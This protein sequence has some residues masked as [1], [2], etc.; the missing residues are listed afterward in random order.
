[1]KNQKKIIITGF[2]ASGKDY[3]ADYLTKKGFK[4]STSYTTRP[5]RINEVDGDVYNFISVEKFQEMI[6][7]DEFYEYEEFL[8]QWYYGSTKKDWNDSNL[9]IKTAG[10]IDQIKKEDRENCFIVYL[11][12][13]EEIILERLAERNDSNDSIQRRISTDREDY[14]N[15]TDYDVKISDDNFNPEDIYLLYI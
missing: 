11:D 13:S 15:F 4:K 6:S 7:N 8:T 9:F 3:L 10:G 1:M 14:S 12:T 2:T 5:I